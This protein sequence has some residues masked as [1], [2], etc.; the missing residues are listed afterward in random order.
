MII[1]FQEKDGLDK[2]KAMQDVKLDSDIKK[3]I[4]MKQTKR[5]KKNTKWFDLMIWPNAEWVCWLF[6]HVLY[7]YAIFDYEE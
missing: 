1:S 5:E 4:H 2:I 7:S 6:Y 3:L